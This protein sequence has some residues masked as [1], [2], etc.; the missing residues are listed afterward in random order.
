MGQSVFLLTRISFSCLFFV[1]H[2]GTWVS[3]FQLGFG[4]SGFV[5]APCWGLKWAGAG[6][7]RPRELQTCILKFTRRFKYHQQIHEKTLGEAT[8]SRNSGRVKEKKG[9]FWLPTLREPHCSWAPPF[10]ASHLSGYGAPPSCALTEEL[11]EVEH[12]QNWPNSRKTVAEVDHP[13]IGRSRSWPKS[14]APGGYLGVCGWLYNVSE[15]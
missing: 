14:T 6:S 3:E 8:T 2:G 7:R 13:K 11:A 10:W 1:I 12:S 15:R 5:T 4:V 9:G